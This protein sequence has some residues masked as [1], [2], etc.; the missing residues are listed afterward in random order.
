M[1][2]SIS[3]SMHVNSSSSLRTVNTRDHQEM[4]VKE[5]SEDQTV[6]QVN[7][8]IQ[9]LDSSPCGGRGG[10]GRQYRV[11]RRERSRLPGNN[12]NLNIKRSHSGARSSS[13]KSQH[14]LNTLVSIP[15]PLPPPS[16][17][18]GRHKENILR[19]SCP[20]S[21]VDSTRPQRSATSTYDWDQNLLPTSATDL[22]VLNEE[23][24]ARNLLKGHNLGLGTNECLGTSSLI[25]G[26]NIH[27]SQTIYSSEVRTTIAGSHNEV[28]SS[29]AAMSREVMDLVLMYRDFLDSLPEVESGLD[30]GQIDKAIEDL[31]TLLEPPQQMNPISGNSQIVLSPPCHNPSKDSHSSIESKNNNAKSKQEERE[32]TSKDATT[33]ANAETKLNSE[34]ESS[35]SG[36][37]PFLMNDEFEDLIKWPDPDFLSYSDPYWF[38]P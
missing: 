18:N 32:G 23:N 16:Q 29:Q 6:L 4:I 1:S 36:L 9:A 35:F 19:G 2:N 21:L 8:S 17:E 14:G 7:V 5:N 24:E 28:G 3:S 12:I 25:K 15:P 22:P 38:D 30:E 31:K 34:V 11:I 20:A 27:G 37:V 33:L 10:G 13:T 26:Q